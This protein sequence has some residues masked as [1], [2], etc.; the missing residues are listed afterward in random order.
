MKDKTSLKSIIVLV[1]ICLVIAIAMAAVNLVTAPKIEEYNIQKQN[2]AL[3]DVLAENGGFE[4]LD[5]TGMPETVTGAWRDMDGEGYAFMLSAKGYD[6]SNPIVIAVGMSNDGKIIKCR[7]V[8][9]TGETAGIG[10]KV[11]ES[12]FTD[13]FGNKD[14][15]LSG[16]DTISGA[17]ISSRAYIGAVKDAFAALEMVKEG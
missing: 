2:E 4:A 6:A 13:L 16:V 5:L 9:A 7:T 8:S 3:A 17:T 1:S 12:E 15:S 11:A 10:S 14:S